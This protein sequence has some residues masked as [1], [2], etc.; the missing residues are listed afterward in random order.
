[1]GPGVLQLSG[2]GQSVGFPLGLARGQL[3]DIILDL[4]QPHEVLVSGGQGAVVGHR[5]RPLRL[6]RF[7]LADLRVSVIELLDELGLTEQDTPGIAVIRAES[8]VLVD[9]YLLVLVTLTDNPATLLLQISRSPRHVDVM[10][11][12]RA[13]L[14]V[15]PGAHFRGVADH[16]IDQAI[17]AVIEQLK[18]LFVPLVDESDAVA[19]HA[20]GYQLIADPVIDAEPA[21]LVGHTL[22]TEHD[23]E[24]ASVRRFVAELVQVHVIPRLLPLCDDLVAHC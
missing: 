21:R 22:V 18:F 8:D 4:Q 15:S 3:L 23:L 17:V 2:I 20:S 16:H 11:R 19:I 24:S 12:D 9:G 10:Q 6:Q 13:R 14:D 1:M 5:V 7:G